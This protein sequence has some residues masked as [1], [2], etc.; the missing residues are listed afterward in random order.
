MLCYRRKLPH[1]IPDNTI[2][3]ITWRLAGTAPPPR[4]AILTAQTQYHQTGPQWL[5][6][7]RIAQIVRNA[8]EYGE[9][10]RNLYT[11]HAWV[12]M[13]NHIHV[14]LEPKAPLPKVMQWLKGRTA[15]LANRILNRTGQPFWHDESYDHWIRS[16]NELN[17]TIAYIENNPK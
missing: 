14:L 16:T 15:R 8:L 11:L 3:F 13:P 5:K 9:T 6:D 1:W 4:P 17:Q 2:I 10:N 12:I 7:P